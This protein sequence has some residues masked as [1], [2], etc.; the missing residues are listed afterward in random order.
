MAPSSACSNLVDLVLSQA[1][2]TVFPTDDSIVSTLQTLFRN[3]AP[4]CRLGDTCMVAI[5]PLRTLGNMAQKSARTYVEQC[6]SDTQWETNGKA[7]PSEALAPHPF[8][9]ALRIYHRMRRTEASQAIVFSGATGSGKSFLSQAITSQILRVSS[10]ATHQ[11]CQLAH[12]VHAMYR[13]L[14]SFGHAKTTQN[15]N[16]SRFNKYVELH[17]TSSGR[18]LGTQILTFGLDKQRLCYPLQANERTYHVFYQLLAG[19]SSDER[20]QFHLEDVTDYRLLASSGCYRLM[21]GPEND[22]AHAFEELKSAMRTLGFRQKQISHI[23]TILS[24]LLLLGNLEFLEPIEFDTESASA[25][26]TDPV[27]LETVSSLLGVES[28]DLQQVLT[29]RTKLVGK[30][31]ISTL[32]SPDAASDQRDSL[33]RNLYATLFAYIVETANHKLTQN[34]TDGTQ[35]TKITYLDVAGT[36]LQKGESFSLASSTLAAHPTFL[37]NFASELVQSWVEQQAFHST[38][39]LTAAMNSDGIHLP[40]PVTGENTACME[41]LRGSACIGGISGIDRKP[42]G[43]FGALCKLTHQVRTNKVDEKDVSTLL[44]TMDGFVAHSSYISS[45]KLSRNAFGI[46][47][48][49]GSCTYDPSQ[50]LADECDMFDASYVHLLRHSSSPFV[51]KLLSGPALAVTPHPLDSSVDAATQVSNRP[52]RQPS[53][54]VPG[55]AQQA[56]LLDPQKPYGATRQ[57]NAALSELLLCMSKAETTWT[58]LAIRPNDIEQPN[59][60][61]VRKVKA[62]VRALLLADLVE[63]KRY[64]YVSGISFED[65]CERYS[66]CGLVQA[67]TAATVTEPREK[68]QAFVI[69]N[70]WREKSDFTLGNEKIWL[71]YPA[72]RRLEDRLRRFEPFDEATS[73]PIA[74]ASRPHSQDTENLVNSPEPLSMSRTSIFPEEENGQLLN[75]RASMSTIDPFHNRAEE[76]SLGGEEE[77]TGKLYYG[78]PSFNAVDVLEK[79]GH[80]SELRDMGSIEEESTSRARVWWVRFV[81]ICTF[82][83]PNRFL[84]GLGGMKRPDVQMAWREKVTICMLIFFSCAF[85]LFYIL[86]FGKILC[87]DQNKAWNSAQLT[88]HATSD[89]YYVAVRGK[90]YDLT[91]FWKIQHS[92]TTTQ[93]TNEVML[94]LGGQD[95]TPYFPVPLTVG[96]PGLVTDASLSLQTNASSTYYTPTIEQAVHQSGTLSD[97]SSAALSNADWYPDTFV[98]FMNKYYKGSFVVSKKE[99]AKQAGDRQWAIVDGKLYDLGDYIYTNSLSTNTAATKFLPSSITEIFS[100]ETGSDVSA[101]FHAAMAS[102]NDSTRAATQ[103]CL[104]NVFYAGKV[105]FRE[106]ARCTVQNYLLLAFSIILVVTI[107]SK[108]LAALQLAPKR[109]PEQQDKF[110]ICQVPC[111]T[112][113]EEE[114]RKTI[115]SLA[116]LTYDDKRKLLFLICDGMI[117]GNGNELP[118]PRIVLDILGVDPQVDPEPLMFKSV[119]EGS[120]QLNYGKVYSGLYEFE[121]HV[122]PYI[123]VVKVGRPSERSRP[124]NRGK[125]DTQI[126][127][128]RYLNRVHFD[129]P[130]YPLELEIY[131]QMK[132]VIGID[133]AFY[134]F[135]L[136]V[137]AD[138][139]VEPDGLNRLVSVAADDSKIIAVCGETKLVNEE[140]S[141]WTMI[142]VYEYYISHHLAKAFESLFGSVTCLP[143]CFSMYRIRSADKGRPLF[144]SN[145]IIDEYSENR[146]DTLHKKNLFSLG[147]DR[148]LTTL[149]LKNFPAFSTK[150]TSDAHAQT[151]A[152]DK[153]GVLLSQRRRWINSTIHN[154]AELVMMPEL[155][156][157]CLVSLQGFSV[158]I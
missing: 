57:I 42:G 114:L 20:Q 65:F 40:E 95:L 138:T 85:V 62:Q 5:N 74:H 81:S 52:L 132:N 155:C 86:A 33:V 100:G 136:M 68:I 84:S 122:V 92:D 23:F 126:L 121:G 38:C 82:Y 123:V 152:P 140:G 71:A 105:D 8:D 147:E 150:F 145:R 56:S 87:P 94:Q 9:L 2:S 39:P 50:F 66:S 47:H 107:A 80:V 102:L 27:R 49:Q 15:S 12:Q 7:S 61:E 154:L 99:I 109:N 59:L 6:Y 58:V 67:A 116:A 149:I 36:Q 28:D 16:A 51:A 35:T 112:E 118:T 119:A 41:L 141:W 26:V 70:A 45:N 54:L 128:M 156:G 78:Q 1:S 24:A 111:Y 93:V 29:T 89:S 120:K 32:L 34:L 53:P 10:Q 77:D 117:V 64:E 69:A 110:V 108:F 127:L 48:Y 4:Y 22:D 11:E 63:R 79:G 14:E 101:D 13:L 133:P 73:L 130:M 124:G 139:T 157:F 55:E 115:D 18:F 96:C 72:W 143:G 17:F 125:R 97:Q 83:I 134:E 129:A 131:H 151:A 148:Y 43:I 31:V 104:D 90:V 91:K 88:E 44:S 37:F 76:L 153:W 3:N 60:F 21:G 135:I 75:K 25:T 144:I 103:N 158:S 46:N 146:I 19:A 137:D 98:P 113:G 106:S 142:Q 30:Q